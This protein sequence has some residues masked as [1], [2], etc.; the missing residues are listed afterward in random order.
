MAKTISITASDGTT[1]QF[2]DEV[3]GSG[4]MKDVYF[5]PD[6]KY[7]VGFFRNKQDVQSK[8]R[9]KN[10]TEVY[11]DRIFNQAGGQYWE[12][13]F[14]WP[15]KMVEWEGKTGIVCPTYKSHF[16]FSSGPF[17]GK[18]KE[19]KWFASAKLRN[20]FL[21][22]TEKGTW[23]THFHMCIQIARAVKRLHAAGLA[24]S[25]LSYKNVLVDPVTGRA[26]II[27]IDGLVV[28]GKFPPDVMGTPDF[29]APE[30]LET[31]NLPLGDP[32]KKLP[33]I[34]TDRH[35]L[36]VLIYM[37]LLY[38][39]P[40]RGGRVCDLDPAKDEELSMG[41]KALFIEHPTDK[42]NRPKLQQ[43]APSELPQGDISKLP[44]TICGPY[45]KVLFERAF[46][47][48]LHNPSARPT[49]DEWETAL[50]KTTDLMQPCQNST[51]ESHWFVF[52][53]TTKPKCPF[54]GKEY[55][56]QL[57]VMNFYYSPR[58]GE[59]KLENYRLM[60]YDNQTLY[61]W[62]VNRFITPNEKTS[63]A[64][65]RPVGDFHFHN[66]RWIL[67]NRRDDVVFKDVD[68]DREIHRGEFIELTEG[69]KILLSK[70]DGGRL[71]IVQLVNN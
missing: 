41:A 63:D 26:S 62:H 65:K 9:L 47:D 19:G 20:K 45:L 71:V 69:K 27:D 55:H 66:G 51:C 44:Y 42:S 57:P 53:N 36:A 6:K 70:E 21:P 5:S 14:C 58:Q 35:A 50:V 52:D 54:C 18:E 43:L 11:R 39:H 10:I 38:R 59:F 24:H 61:M 8:D 68:S 29:V 4:A 17:K 25:D 23:L 3:I 28:P 49:A 30:V 67:I 13:L 60:V 12:N 37:Y 46:I 48:G 15:T 1:V 64:D 40:L 7:V 31:K 33:S 22:A 16:F 2:V 32:N 34:A 56:G